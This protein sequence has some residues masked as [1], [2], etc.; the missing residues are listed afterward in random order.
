MNDDCPDYN[1]YFVK[2]QKRW[3]AL[4]N[5]CGGCCGAYDDPCEHLRKDSETTYYCE[6]YQERLGERKAVSGDK[7]DCVCVKEILHTHWKN[8]HLCVYKQCINSPWKLIPSGF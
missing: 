2:S 5:R 6:I 7:F 8:D 1:D 4:C 3:E